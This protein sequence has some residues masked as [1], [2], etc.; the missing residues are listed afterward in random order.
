MLHA[1]EHLDDRSDVDHQPGF[2]EHFARDGRFERLA[3]LHAAAGQTPFALQ[4]FVRAPDQQ[5][6]AVT[7]EHDRADA[8]DRSIGKPS[9]VLTSSHPHVLSLKSPSP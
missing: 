9:H 6:A 8:D 4:R 2:F 3:E 7:V 5:H 1:I